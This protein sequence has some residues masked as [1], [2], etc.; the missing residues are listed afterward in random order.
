[1][2]FQEPHAYQPA[3]AEKAQEDFAA[4]PNKVLDVMFAVLCC[5]ASQTLQSS[6]AF[7]GRLTTKLRSK[8]ILMLCKRC[9]EPKL[10]SQLTS[11]LASATMQRRVS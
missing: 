6:N 7:V 2:S 9:L 1:M 10:C 11:L 4:A 5:L 3:A 8:G